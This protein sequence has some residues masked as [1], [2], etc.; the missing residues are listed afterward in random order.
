MAVTRAGCPWEVDRFG[1]RNCGDRCGSR[2]VAACPS[3]RARIRESVIPMSAFVPL[4]GCLGTRP[5]MCS[6]PGHSIPSTRGLRGAPWGFVLDLD[7]CGRYRRRGR[8][9]GR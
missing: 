9:G 7:Q 4:L 1:I 8:I 6:L 5:A 2:V 3:G